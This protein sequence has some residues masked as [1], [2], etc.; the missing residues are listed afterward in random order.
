[1]VVSRAENKNGRVFWNCLCDCGNKKIVSSD[2]LTTGK[3]TS[4][5]CYKREKLKE[6]WSTSCSKDPKLY[7]VWCSMKSRCYRPSDKGYKNYGGRGIE[8]CPEWLENY[9]NFY[10]W[11]M[12]NGYQEG[13]QIDRIDN[14]KGYSP[15]NCRWVDR[16]VQANNKR[17]IKKYTIN[18]KTQSLAEWCREYDVDYFLARQRISKLGWTIEQALTIAPCK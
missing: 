1:L 14:D 15:D 12:N 16:Y 17:N 8:I 6:L 2:C 10:Q 13:L 18:G 7:G 5:G 3:T 4:C 9:E 11:A